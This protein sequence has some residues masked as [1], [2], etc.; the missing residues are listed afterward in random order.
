MWPVLV[1]VGQFSLH[2]YGFL[3]A[4]AFVGIALRALRASPSLGLTDD[5]MTDVLF[6]SSVAG[7]L[8]SRMFFVAQSPDSFASPAEWLNPRVGGLV[9]YG[10]PL[11]GLP[12]AMW[13]IRRAGAS[14]RQVL[15][16]FAVSLP[17][18]HGVSRFG[19]LAAGCCYGVPTNGWFAVTYSDPRAM[20]PLGVPL[21]PIQPVE[22]LI[23]IGLALAL[24]WRAPHRAF[25]GELVAGWLGGYG[26]LRIL[27]ELFRGDDRGDLAGL[28]PSTA[29]SLVMVGGAVVAMWWGRR[30]GRDGVGSG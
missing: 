30:A 3:G 9:F 24:A 1:Q 5:Q 6:W 28:S 15:D 20:A 19:C 18:G 11:V 23:E 21:F 8:G 16:H 13:V 27:T 25:S 17:F 7:L 22:G 14:I 4:V 26:V 12:V 2:T 10:A 29:I